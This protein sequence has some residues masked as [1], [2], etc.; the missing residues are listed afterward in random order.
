MCAPLAIGIFL[1]ETGLDSMLK[2]KEFDFCLLFDV[3]KECL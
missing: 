2:M 3:A 1:S